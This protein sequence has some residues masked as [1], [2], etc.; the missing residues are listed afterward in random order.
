MKI[1]KVRIRHYRSIADI[2]IECDDLV[3]LVGRN[4]AGKSCILRA[5]EA[6]YDSGTAMSE[7]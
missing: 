1:R 5:L 3:A 4:G 6:F 7:C 2:E